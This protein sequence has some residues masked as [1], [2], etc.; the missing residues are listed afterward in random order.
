MATVVIVAGTAGT[1]KSTIG[2]ALRD[3]YHTSYLEADDVHPKEVRFQ[4]ICF[5]SI[6]QHILTQ[7]ERR[8]DG[9]GHP[10]R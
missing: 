3:H 1:G 7:T 6:L 10:I 9:Q 8:E 2:E 5:F 4:T